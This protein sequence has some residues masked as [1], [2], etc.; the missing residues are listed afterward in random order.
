M[1]FVHREKI[2]QWQKFVYLYNL[3]YFV[4]HYFN[5]S[6]KYF[7]KVTFSQNINIIYI[8]SCPV[9]IEFNLFLHSLRSNYYFFNCNF[10]SL[11]MQLFISTR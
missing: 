2:F 1:N 3:V 11:Q 9:D 5:K 10:Y 7:R 4:F 6:A 8:A